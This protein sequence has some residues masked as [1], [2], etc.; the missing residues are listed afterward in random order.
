MKTQTNKSF[1][2]NLNSSD[3]FF[4]ENKDTNIFRR[5]FTTK[6]QHHLATCR[7]NSKQTTLTFVYTWNEGRPRAADRLAATN[8]VPCTRN[9]AVPAEEPVDPAS[10][11]P[12]PGDSIWQVPWRPEINWRP[13][14]WKGKKKI[15][16]RMFRLANGHWSLHPSPN[17]SIFPFE[18][19]DLFYL[20]TSQWLEM[21][22]H[23]YLSSEIIS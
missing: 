1:S 5:Q 9:R 13:A 12:G 11:R 10:Q 18:P 16:K 6:H 22:L 15:K 23:F 8:P 21:W 4:C 7:R 17:A 14:S 19:D 3:P 2:F 20:T